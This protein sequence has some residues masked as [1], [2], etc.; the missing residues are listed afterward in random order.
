MLRELNG[1]ESTTSAAGETAAEDAGERASK[2]RRT[3]GD[4]SPTKDG[5]LGPALEW[6]WDPRDPVPDPTEGGEDAGPGRAERAELFLHAWRNVWSRKA[7]GRGASTGGAAPAGSARPP[8]PLLELR[9]IL[10]HEPAPSTQ[11]RLTA[12]W[13]RGLD[14]DRAAFTG[15]FG[16]VTR[17]VGERLKA[18]AG[19]ETGV[20]A[21]E[22]GIA[23]GDGD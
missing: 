4:T 16:F 10:E 6:R 14:A 3:E 21:Q 5:A 22:R 12:H 9:I 18:E 17:K 7:R 15:L 20:A 19:T 8:R 23:G 1:G 13:T 11:V 2:R